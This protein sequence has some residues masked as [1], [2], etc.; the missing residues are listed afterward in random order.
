M[1]D[2][3][4]QQNAEEAASYAYEDALSEASAWLASKPEN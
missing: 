1:N 2:N 4:K 3:N